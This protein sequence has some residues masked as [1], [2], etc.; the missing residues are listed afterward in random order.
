M[1]LLSLRIQDFRNLT[2]VELAP[3]PGLNLIVGANAA[4]KTSLLEGIFFLGHGRSFRS[5]HPERLIREGTDACSVVGQ[6]AGGGGGS[7]LTVGIERSRRGWRARI[8]G[9]PVRG[10]AELAGQLPTQ[11]INPDSHRLLEGGPQYR[12]RFLDWGVFHV[13]HRFLGAWQRY[14]RA[15]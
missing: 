15:L 5:R 3:S 8:G 4:G 9:A 7:G 12:R 11:L 13:E 1:S 2:A 6:V 14:M 10:L